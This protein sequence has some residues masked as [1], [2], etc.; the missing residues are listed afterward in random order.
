MKDE[1]L[2]R[3]HSNLENLHRA[4]TSAGGRVVLDEELDVVTFLI[5]CARNNIELSAKFVKPSE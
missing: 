5:I 1:V 2:R 4:I 3:Y